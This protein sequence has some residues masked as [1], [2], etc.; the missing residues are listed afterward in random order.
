[1]L[2]SVIN[3]V[4]DFEH[5]NMAHE[6]IAQVFV[7]LLTH[8]PSENLVPLV[9]DTNL[10]DKLLEAQRLW[11]AERKV[12]AHPPPYLAYLHLIGHRLV[13]SAAFHADLTAHC[14]LA[15][16]IDWAML[17]EELT[18]L[19]ESQRRLELEEIAPLPAGYPPEPKDTTSSFSSGDEDA[20]AP[21]SSPAPSTPPVAAKVIP[22]TLQP[23]SPYSDA[24]MSATDAE[25]LMNSADT[26]GQY[27]ALI[28]NDDL[29]A[30]LEGATGG[31]GLPLTDGDALLDAA[32][33][34]GLDL[35]ASTA[36]AVG[37]GRPRVAD[38]IDS[39]L[40][41]TLDDKVQDANGDISLDDILNG[42]L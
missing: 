36:E 12:E 6:L 35:A 41:G 14:E 8:A 15:G 28:M 2:L 32:L 4:L 7:L 38:A 3:Q 33:G 23:L 21:K 19:R 24:S 11:I 16:G 18:K 10:V 13:A 29:D 42:S 9:E 34:F 40:D 27:D 26:E 30:L 5:C 20:P 22:P 31:G 39:L 37:S 1:V 25:A 17:K